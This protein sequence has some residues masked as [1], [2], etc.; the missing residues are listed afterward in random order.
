[1]LFLSTLSV[2]YST[3]PIYGANITDSSNIIGIVKDGLF[4]VA[5]TNE[6]K[7]LT[8]IAPMEAVTPESGLVNLTQYEGKAI[9]V[10]SPHVDNEWI[11]DP[12]IIDIAD[13]IVTKLVEKVFHL[14]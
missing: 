13:P 2:I 7:K 6:T 3:M 11:F 4:I 9:L 8:S 14:K 5:E 12:T 1:M 10:S